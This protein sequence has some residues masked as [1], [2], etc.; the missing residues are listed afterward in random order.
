MCIYVYIYIFSLFFVLSSFI[1]FCLI[2]SLQCPVVLEFL[3]SE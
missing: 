2:L 3:T 1:I